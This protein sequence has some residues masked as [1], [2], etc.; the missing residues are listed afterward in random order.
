MNRLQ[1]EWWEFAIIVDRFEIFDIDSYKKVVVNPF[2]NQM[3]DLLHLFCL[4]IEFSI[5]EVYNNQFFCC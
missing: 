3:C 1:G 2:Q 4:H 5:I